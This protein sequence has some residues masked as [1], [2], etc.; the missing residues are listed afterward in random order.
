GTYIKLLR[1]AESVSSDVLKMIKA[2]N[3]TASQFGVLEALF[4]LGPMC[5][6]ELAIKI[7][8]STGNI[9]LVVDNLEK[10]KLVTRKVHKKDRRF[11]TIALTPKGSELIAKLFPMHAQDITKRM[12][13]LS[14]KE[15][16][17]LGELCKKLKNSVQPK[18]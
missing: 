2:S 17:Q 3:L 11:F 12:D 7:L 14:T 16:I 18:G 13:L 9:T 4:H 15:Q 10:R 6:K 8:K 5:Q 1:A